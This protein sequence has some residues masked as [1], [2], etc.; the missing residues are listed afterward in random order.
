MGAGIDI[1]EVMRGYYPKGGGKVLVE[2]TM[3]E[4]GLK[5]LELRSQGKLQGFFASIHYANLPEHISVRIKKTVEVELKRFDSNAELEIE[6]E[7]AE[8]S[9]S[10]GVGL[11]LRAIFD[12]TVLCSS[13]LGERGVPAEKLAKSASMRLIDE[14]RSG[15][16]AD[17]HT[18][19]QLLP[20]LI[21]TQSVILAKNPIT[22]HTLTNLAVIRQFYGSIFKQS[23][24]G[25]VIEI[26]SL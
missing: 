11:T 17:A 13:A 24:Q 16:T 3:P 6:V 26:K 18:A 5:S 22:A 7:K 15:A 20:Y 23:E 21:G 10:P 25:Q 9:R 8:Q 14:I 2:I 19:D 4:G 1:K 12:N